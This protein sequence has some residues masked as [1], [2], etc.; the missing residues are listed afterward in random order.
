MSIVLVTGAN[1]LLGSSLVPYLRAIGHSVICISRQ[2]GADLCA[3]FSILN[4]AI[5]CLSLVNPDTIINLAA[6]TDVDACE[7]DTDLA[8][9]ANVSIVENIVTW[10]NLKQID[11]HLVQISTDQLYDG[12]GPHNEDD[13]TL[14][15]AYAESKHTAERVAADVSST[16]LRTNFFGPSNCAGRAS[17]SDWVLASLSSSMEI[18]VFEDI[19]F[20]PL[21]ISTLVELIATVASRRRAGIFNLG[22]KDGMSKADFAYAL[23]K[24]LRLPT[25]T[26]K[27]GLSSSVKLH[28]YRPKDMRMDSTLFEKTFAV[29]LPT[30]QRE[31]ESMQEVYAGVAR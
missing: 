4:E 15:N 3:D 8:Y 26:M 22:S 7:R 6:M 10:I 30:L 9:S 25:R 20:S 17:I 27:R 2:T 16:I 14:T 21:S 31:V 29:N 23:A 11:S 19:L 24:V 1:G 13:V 18:T 12:P 28:A 5:R